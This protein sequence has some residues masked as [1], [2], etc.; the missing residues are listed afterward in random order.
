MNQD[1]DINLIVRFFDLDLSDKELE[2]FEKR[3]ENDIEFRE[4]FETYQSANTLVNKE[5]LDKDKQA[6]IA[7]MKTILNA[8]KTTKPTKNIPWKWL[9]G[10]AASFFIALFIYQY[11]SDCKQPDLNNIIVQSW[12][13]KVGLDFNTIRSGQKDSTEHQIIKAYKAY[14]TKNYASALNLLKDYKPNTTN[15]EDVLLIKSL[16]YYKKHEVNI[17]LKTLDTLSK[18]H[19][20]KKSEVAN[21][22]QGL[23]YLEQGNIK[24]AKQFIKLPD[25]DTKTLQVKE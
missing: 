15:Y 9:S 1:K 23:I 13:K 17:A 16:S 25:K 10:I 5:Y 11:T 12:D 21:W 2:T 19:T 18:Y 3:L 6:R 8:K 4:K 22:Y 20:G 14:D 7:E 24:K